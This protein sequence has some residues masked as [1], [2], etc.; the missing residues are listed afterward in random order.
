MIQKNNIC[1]M[2]QKK[3]KC[4]SIYKKAKMCIMIQE[5][6]NV[7]YARVMQ[8]QIAQTKFC[9]KYLFNYDFALVQIYICEI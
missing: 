3:Q 6:R 4:V 1:I 5:S 8:K 7:Y 2:V 9:V